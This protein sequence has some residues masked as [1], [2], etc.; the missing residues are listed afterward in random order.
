[1]S[2]PVAELETDRPGHRIVSFEH[3]EGLARA[4]GAFGE[5][6]N[7]R[8]IENCLDHRLQMLADISVGSVLAYDSVKGVPSSPSSHVAGRFARRGC[9][10]GGGGRA[11]LVLAGGSDETLYS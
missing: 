10:T 4:T 7:A 8:A 2:E 3:C 11:L 1:M 9:S 5:H 6:E